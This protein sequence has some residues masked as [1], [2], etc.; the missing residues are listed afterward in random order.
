M[1]ASVFVYMGFNWNGEVGTIM[2]CVVCVHYIHC[3]DGI[4]EVNVDVI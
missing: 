1:L 3:R 4:W 2:I